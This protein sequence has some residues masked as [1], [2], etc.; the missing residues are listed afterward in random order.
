LVRMAA[1]QKVGKYDVFI[2][3]CG[4]DCKEDFA[5]LVRDDLERAGV[6]CFLDEPS[7]EVGKSAAEEM[8]K[9]VEEATYGVVIISPDFFER[10]WCLKELETFVRRGR[11]VPV[12]LGDFAA[13]QAAAE[14]AVAKGV[15]R[16][17]GRFEWSEEG[18]QVLVRDST[19]FVGVKLAEK[20]WWRTCIRRVR[21]EVLRLLGK[22]G[23]GIRISE[24]ELLVGQEEHLRELKRLLGVRQEGVQGT[25]GVQAAGEVGIVGVKG[26][27]GVG[28]TTLAKKLYDEADVR[29]WFEGNIC[30]LEV[31]PKPSDDKI[32]DLQKQIL[33]QL[34]E[35][36]EDPGNPSRG[37]QLIRQRLSGKRVLICLDDVWEAVLVETAVVDVSD[38]APGSRILK[39]SRKRE[40]IGGHVH[41]LDSLKPEPAWELF[42]WHAF[43]GEE[44][45]ES[46]AELAKG[47][48]ARCGGLPLALKL[49]GRQLAQAEDK[50]KRLEDFI[51]LPLDDD[52]MIGV[53][54]VIRA[55]YDNLPAEPRGLRDVFILVAG[56][57][58]RTPEFMQHQ[59]AVENLGAA[60]YGSAPR[61]T[62]FRLAEKALDKLN[63]LSLVGLKE[64][65]NDGGLSL[66]VHDLIV[67]VAETLADG[68]EQGGERFLCQRA[69]AEGLEMP[70]DP[71][72]LEH[73]SIRSGSLSIEKVPAACSLVL[74][75]GAELVGS[76]PDGD[77]PSECR[78]L[79]MEE[80]HSVRLHDLGKLRCLRLRR[81]SFDSFPPGL[82][83]LGDL[84]VLEVRDCHALASL[85]ES[86]GKL[87]GLTSL[88]LRGCGA[89]RGLPE[90]IGA[91]T[92]LTSLDLRGCRALRGLPESFGALAGLM[93][94][95]LEECTA[96]QGL[97]ESVGALTGLTSIHLRECGRLAGLP[98]SIK[99]LTGLTRLN[100]CECKALTGLPESI[101][102]LT[103]LT[104]M[105][106][107]WC[108][109]LRTLPDSIGALT[110]L[111]SLDLSWCYE[112]RGLPES[113]GALTG[114]TSLNL[115][116]SGLQSLPES[117]G[118]LETLISL[119]LSFCRKLRGLPESFGRLR[120]LTSLDLSHCWVLDT[121]PESVGALTRLTSLKLG[122]CG[123]LKIQPELI[124]A[125]TGLTS[126]DSRL[127][128]MP[129]ALEQSLGT[130]TG[131]ESVNMSTRPTKKLPG[132]HLFTKPFEEA[133]TKGDALARFKLGNAYKLAA[134][135]DKDMARSAVELYK[136][137]AEQGLARARVAL[138]DC[139]AVGE[140]VE[141]DEPRA[142]ELYARATEQGDANAQ[143]RLGLCY[144]H[145]R[146]VEKDTAKAVQLYAKAAEQ[147]NARGQCYLGMCYTNGWGVEKD[148]ARAAEL[149]A[150]AAHQGDAMAQSNLGGCYANGTGVEKDEAHAA[151]LY[152]KAAKQYEHGSLGEDEMRAA[153]LYAKAADYCH[154][155]A[156]CCLGVCYETGRGVAKDEAK[157]A[158]LYAKAAEQG[159]ATAQCCLGVC[160]E[161]G[162]G[163]AKDEAKAA[164][165]Y[166][167]AAEQ[168]DARAQCNLG[169]CYSFGKGV[170][171]DEG[172]A[173]EL[174]AKAAEQ[175]DARGQCYLGVCYTHGRGVGKDE[176]KAVELYARAA[177][178]GLAEGQFN[179]GLC[180]EH[181][182]GVEKDEAHAAELYKR[183][184]EQGLAEGQFNLGFCYQ[185]GK[186]VEKDEARAAELYEKAADQGLSA[187]QGNLGELYAEGL[188][189]R[190][191]WAAAFRLF[192]SAAKDAEALSSQLFLAWLLWHG[193][194]TAQDRPRAE[195]LCAKVRATER[196][197]ERLANDYVAAGEVWP[198]VMR[199]FRSEVWRTD[200][201]FGEAVEAVGSERGPRQQADGNGGGTPHRRPAPLGEG[202]LAETSGRADDVGESHGGPSAVRADAARF[203]GALGPERRPKLVFSLLF[204]IVAVVALVVVAV[205][206]TRQRS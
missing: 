102:A 202:A 163:V 31:G 16:G 158:E 131:L 204:P 57:W 2:S 47:A 179:L 135:S 139:Y 167:K 159:H 15:W 77:G 130:F 85:P 32:R 73:L 153:E 9:A 49:L 70:R 146:G 1:P 114:L 44:P 67:D 36:D 151:E 97:P 81:G 105:D 7:L 50:K 156:Q 38:L 60:V 54:T 43:G 143:Y 8:L 165:L 150:K 154:A 190:Q 65:G 173:A 103:G 137:A 29:E 180:Y 45:P 12:F 87:T 74:S 144:E 121:V 193:R 203:G 106:S 182:R 51:A 141:K 161:T 195:G 117:M 177:Q 66:T 93:S 176:A 40:S 119:D 174:Y 136:K 76:L 104:S 28:K 5:D 30:W 56:V 86:F 132:L 48:A 78:L 41:D 35:V 110:R 46:L 129:A 178:Q 134:R 170:E 133:A 99:S 69:D 123:K 188:G 18:Y 52:A 142:A 25:S 164:E 11:I 199:W 6:L 98:A 108:D 169:L 26:M 33:K 116:W 20:G 100:L 92:G 19:K 112:V 175:G 21:D 122:G 196:Y 127:C 149:Y 128:T 171:K 14:A 10:E 89:L 95:L 91:L 162:R 184:A 125:L 61:S 160:Y 13:I 82:E 206:G 107:S 22:V 80:V 157:A 118:A 186:G 181:G 189:V 148:E 4:D 120:S 205:N 140:G 152:A 3:H 113:I 101:S 147:D 96:L 197:A 124:R 88:D 111:T 72:K 198:A 23:G 79:D 55:S 155:G 64:D 53:R 192:E 37:R 109:M 187:G 63:S 84:C 138:G 194:G 126:L 166:A 168:G 115:A 75:P 191:D 42:C 200:E 17:F 183:A 34:G 24:D 27:G 145:S 59:R 68:T 83:N 94:L 201:S 58:P 172:R 71:R 90:S 62:R 185:F 39:T